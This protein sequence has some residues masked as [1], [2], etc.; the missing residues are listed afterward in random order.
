MLFKLLRQEQRDD[1]IFTMLSKTSYPGWRYMKENDATTLWEM[2]EKNLPGHSL[3]HSSFLFPGAW[4]IEGLAGI[5]KDRP[6]FSDII[7]KQPYLGA[8]QLEWV[9]ASFE[10]PSGLIETR[11][12]RNAG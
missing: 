9:K 4:F 6:G 11:W 10:A 3:L 2:W 7:I 8:H 5:K 1:L 12:Q